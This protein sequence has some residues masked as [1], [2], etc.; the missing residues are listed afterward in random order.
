MKAYVTSIG[1][2]TTDLCK[3]SLERNGFE[4]IMLKDDSTLWAKL[5]RI[6]DIADED[7]VRVDA[8][9]IVNR[10]F[11]P[12]NLKTIERIDYLQQ[13]WW[14]QFVAYDWY[15]Q[16]ICHTLS[17][18]KKE[19]LPVLRTNVVRFKDD[20]RPE[21]QVSRVAELHNP[22]RMETYADQLMGI[23]G[24]GISNTKPVMKLKAERGQSHLYD[25]E[26]AQR[27]NEL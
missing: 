3:W 17:Y 14:I 18:I 16:D 12:G 22:R 23:H 25:F 11:T 21:T 10:N 5:K 15:K 20:L 2:P 4:V 26:L 1:E 6:Y 8:D 19:A 7:F 9:I 13:A 24:Y 27:L